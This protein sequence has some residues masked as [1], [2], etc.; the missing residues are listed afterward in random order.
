MLQK[1]W[2]YLFLREFYNYFNTPI[3]YVFLIVGLFINFSFFFI[4]V[5]GIVPA[6]WETQQASIR[7]YMT[8][9]P[10]SFILLVPAVTM[11]LWSEERKVGTIEILRT[12]PV[13]DLDLIVGKFLA[14]WFF[15]VLLIIASL[16]LAFLTWLLGSNFDWGSTMAMYF[17]AILMAGA[18][19][20]LGLVISAITREQ[21][22]AFIL[23]FLI[24]LF[25]FLSNYYILNKHMEPKIAQVVGFFSHSYHYSS[26]S[27]GAIPL[28]DVFYYI[29]FIALM[30]G[31][32]AWV[33][34]R[35]K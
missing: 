26:F 22:V 11:R 35:E 19:V 28:N 23:I 4:G 33:L 3:G 15:V 18:Y 12:L 16:P 13:S 20:S 17:G 6:F 31:I 32:N 9:L 1:E 5:F 34:R 14:A 27:R 24:S 25:M 30:L 7:G 2:K 10:V 21:I 29:S 8:L